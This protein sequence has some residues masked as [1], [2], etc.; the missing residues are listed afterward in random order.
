MVESRQPIAAPV[1]VPGP[2]KLAPRRQ[3][4]KIKPT[5]RAWLPLTWAWAL[6][7][8]GDGDGDVWI[9]NNAN[10]FRLACERA[11]QMRA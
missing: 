9:A 2:K 6:T 11:R 10:Q 7:F 1:S 8:D 4:A 5:R 3:T